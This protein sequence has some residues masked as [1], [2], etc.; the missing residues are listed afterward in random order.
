MSKIKCILFQKRMLLDWIAKTSKLQQMQDERELLKAAEALQCQIPVQFCVQQLIAQIEARRDKLV[1]LE[2]QWWDTLCFL[3]IIKI[4]VSYVS[5][6][7]V[8]G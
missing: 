1:K 2:F 6:S 4:I 3:N 8:H 5:S 7:C